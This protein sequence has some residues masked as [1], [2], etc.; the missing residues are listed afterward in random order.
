MTAYATPVGDS[1]WPTLPKPDP[2]GD[3]DPD[4]WVVIVGT[5]RVRGRNT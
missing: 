5:R 3:P 1:P 2:A 4:S